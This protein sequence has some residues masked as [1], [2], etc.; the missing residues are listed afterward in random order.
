MIRP[1][2]VSALRTRLTGSLRWRVMLHTLAFAGIFVLLIGSVSYLALRFLLA[3]SIAKQ[4]QHSAFIAAERLEFR[5]GAI[6]GDLQDLAGNALVANALADSEGRALYLAPFLRDHTRLAQVPTALCLADFR[7]RPVACNGEVEAAPGWPRRIVDEGQPMARIGATDVTLGLPVIYRPTGRPEGMLLAR[8]ALAPLLVESLHNVDPAAVVRLLGADETI[9]CVACE[10]LGHTEFLSGTEPLNEL[11]PPLLPL[12]LR[13]EISIPAAAAMAPLHR[14]RS[15]YAAIALAALALIVWIA[16]AIAARLIAPLTALTEAAVRIADGGKLD[17]AIAVE[18]GDEIGRLAEAFRRMLAHL[19][20]AHDSLEERVRERTSTLADRE[21][22]LAESESRYR[23]LIAAAPDAVLVAD[24][25]RF[26]FANDVAARLLGAERRDQIVGRKVLDFVMPGSKEG[27]RQLLTEMLS[28]IVPPMYETRVLGL[29]GVIRDVESSA[30]PM[31]FDGRPAIL[32]FLRDLTERRRH[33]EHQRLAAT[34]FE[35]T[36]EGILI[37]DRDGTI[38]AVNRAFTEVT[39]FSSEEAIGRTPAILRS[40]RQSRQF[41][42]YMWRELLTLGEW[43]GEIWNRR[44]NGEIYP[45]WIS[46]AAV[47]GSDG[48]ASHFVAIFT[49]ITTIKESERRLEHLAY[50]DP[51]TNLPNRALFYERLRHAISERA[52]D[53]GRMA[54]LFIDL[55]R[56]KL[57]NDSLGHATGDQLLKRVAERIGTCVRNADTVA[58]LGGDEFTVLLV[59]PENEPA[60]TEVVERIRES[61]SRPFSIDGHELYSGSSIGI[62]LYPEHGKDADALVKAADTAMYVAKVAGHHGFAWFEP[63]MSA[64]S[65][66]DLRLETEL[67][68]A[69]AKNELLLHYQPQYT[70]KDGRLVGYEALVRWNHP[71]RGLLQSGEFL[72]AA[73]KSGLVREVDWWVLRSACRQH[74]LWR[75]QG[76]G[77]IPVA[78][79]FSSQNIHDLRLADELAAVLKTFELDGSWLELEI[80]EHSVMR[81]STAAGRVLTAIKKLGVRVAIDDFGTGYSSLGYI[82]RFPLDTL[83]IDRSFITGI[84]DDDLDVAI[85]QAI[86]GMARALG[87]RVVAEGIETEAQLMFLRENGC[88]VGQGY[89]LGRPGEI[90]PEP[91]RANKSR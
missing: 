1:R 58:R 53:D 18:R 44:K 26:L 85:V 47:R 12:G 62:A 32:A 7:G 13:F 49:D 41:Y 89:L 56:F 45:E 68:A 46:I 20:A 83:K 64:A 35:Y 90:K 69:M 27:V 22:Q 9:A 87:L 8:F 5:L 74:R 34:V 48:A 79:N 72:P 86:L 16:H 50:Y 6:Y 61:L 29:D 24:S 3:E 14:L 2:P 80:T 23:A 38:V 77:E 59:K 25:E 57:I 82:K 78:V 21:R 17:A 54:L 28:G 10:R 15:G 71:V 76:R 55:D 42:R 67:R 65:D 37:T 73:E 63:T 33:E 30:L 91:V 75:D 43:H 81:N 52:R 11:P 19:H 66:D 60:V 36:R 40:G 70:I 39:G 88:E 84:P 31:T 4:M 51:L